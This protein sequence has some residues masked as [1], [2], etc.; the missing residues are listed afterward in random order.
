MSTGPAPDAA[1]A[2]TGAAVDPKAAL[3]TPVFRTVTV[4]WAL[5]NFADSVLTL[6]LAVWVTDLTGNVALGGA[7]FALLGIPALASPFLGQLADRFSRRRLISLAYAGGAACLVP[8][9][10]V[11]DASQV[12]VVYVVTVLYSS[13]AYVTGACQSGLLRDLMPDV[14]LGHA[15][16]RLSMI[17][18]TFRIAMPF[19]GAGVYAVAGPVP[20]VVTTMAAF[21]GAAVIF[22]LVRL[23]ESAHEPAPEAETYLARLT[24]G[25]RHLFGTQPLAGLTVATLGAMAASGLINS[26]AFALLDGVGVPAAWLGPVTVVQG[27]AGFVAG[28]LTPR[29]MDRFGRVPVLAGGLVVAGLGMALMM[30]E[31]LVLTVLAMAPLGFGITMTVIAYVTERQISTPARLQGRA[32][33]ASHLLNNFPAVIF[34][35]LGAALLAVVDYRVLLAVNAVALIAC[36]VFAARLTRRPG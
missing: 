35:L 12:W 15:N 33:A 28:L 19:A 13:V 31:V 2:A 16:G 11:H 4:G 23:T 7:T 30:L 5:S 1:V 26:V 21:G 9:L 24:A 36:G 6:I 17:D 20:L 25:F 32:A 18:Q 34:T 3:R 10:W 8:L 27:L 14:A 29:L 22:A